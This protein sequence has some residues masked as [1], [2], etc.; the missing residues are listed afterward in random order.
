MNLDFLASVV[1]KW[2]LMWQNHLG[3]KKMTSHYETGKKLCTF[4]VAQY[5]TIENYRI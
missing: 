3:N 4:W 1:K 5:I 2:L